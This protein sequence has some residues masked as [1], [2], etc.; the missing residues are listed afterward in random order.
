LRALGHGITANAASTNVVYRESESRRLLLNAEAM[1]FSDGNV[2]GSLAGQY[3]QRLM[4]EPH[5]SVDAIFG[6]AAT[7]DTANSN[8]PYFNPRQ[9]ALATVGVS[10]KQTIYRRY[11]FAYDHHLVVSPGVY[12]EQGF[13]EGGAASVLYEHRLRMNDVFEAGLG[14]SFS[15]QPYDGKYESTTAVLFNLRL[16]L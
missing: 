6:M 10:F 2:R 4:T 3:S 13:G 11:E 1:N 8:R 16:R 9:D 15:R 14:V 7:R 12:W 5:F